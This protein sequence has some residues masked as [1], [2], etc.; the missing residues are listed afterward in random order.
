VRLEEKDL[1]ATHPEYEAY[2]KR[3]PMLIPRF[4]RPKSAAPST[5]QEAA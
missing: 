5:V 1:L 4:A 2:R 3:V